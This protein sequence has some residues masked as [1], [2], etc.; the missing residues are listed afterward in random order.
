[1]PDFSAIVD[2]EDFKQ[3]KHAKNHYVAVSGNWF[4]NINEIV[5]ISAQVHRICSGRHIESTKLICV[6]LKC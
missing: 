6:D 3:L 1:M 5:K 2:I 4:S